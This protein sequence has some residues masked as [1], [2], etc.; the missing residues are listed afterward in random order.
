MCFGIR[1]SSPFHLSTFPITIQNFKS[2]Q[3][4]KNAGISPHLSK[5]KP[6]LCRLRSMSPHQIVLR[7]G[8]TAPGYWVLKSA[9][10]SSISSDLIEIEIEKSSVSRVLWSLHIQAREAVTRVTGGTEAKNILWWL[11]GLLNVDNLKQ[12]WCFADEHN[13]HLRNGEQV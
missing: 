13:S 1:I 11:S 12:I 8:G 4:A 2:P 6:E 3:N 9:I 5:M 7:E 10:I